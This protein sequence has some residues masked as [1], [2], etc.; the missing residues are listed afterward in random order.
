MKRTAGDDDTP[1]AYTRAVGSGPFPWPWERWILRAAH[2]R[3]TEMLDNYGKV[4]INSVS[5]PEV[6]DHPDR[7]Y[8]YG[9]YD[10]PAQPPVGP[11]GGGWSGQTVVYGQGIVVHDRYFTDAGVVGAV[12]VPAQPT[13][14]LANLDV[15]GAAMLRRACQLAERGDLEAAL[16]LLSEIPNMDDSAAVEGLIRSSAG[17]E[18][19]LKLVRSV[20]FRAGAQSKESPAGEVGKRATGT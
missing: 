2:G 17:R 18:D 16:E 19:L 12:E 3:V 7:S 11:P 15:A 20:E 5:P 8:E 6:G 1:A 14:P 4:I 13:W 9:D 10:A